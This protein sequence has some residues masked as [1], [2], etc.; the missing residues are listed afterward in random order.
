MTI[1]F[2]RLFWHITYYKV[3]Y[4]HF[5]FINLKFI[6]DISSCFNHPTNISIES[7]ELKSRGIIYKL[8][9]IH[10]RNRIMK[11]LSLFHNRG[12]YHIETS[13]LIY[14]ANQ[15]FSFYLIETSVMKELPESLTPFTGLRAKTSFSYGVC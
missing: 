1:Q 2:S 13:P 8:W 5:F 4:C 7:S 14:S 10:I 15:C 9:C 12:P 6:S 11:T 3:R